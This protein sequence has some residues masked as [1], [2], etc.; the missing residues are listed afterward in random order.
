MDQKMTSNRQKAIDAYQQQMFFGQGLKLERRPIQF[1]GVLERYNGMKLNDEEY[2][3]CLAHMEG[4]ISV[5]QLDEI[6]SRRRPKSINDIRK[7]MGYGPMA[8]TR[9]NEPKEAPKASPELVEKTILETEIYREA[10][11]AIVQHPTFGSESTKVIMD[12]QRKQ[13]AYGLDKYPEPLN[14]NTWSIEETVQHILDES[15]DKLHYLVM[16][17]IK[18]RQYLAS[19][20]NNVV[21]FRNT[22]SRIDAISRMIDDT[23]GHM[24]YLIS[25]NNKRPNDHMDAIA[26]SMLMMSGADM[27]GDK[28]HTL[29]ADGIP[30][31]TY[32][33]SDQD[34]MNREVL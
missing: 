29:Y 2:N 21:D 28:T 4:H 7:E 10:R 32:T 17:R 24:D 16:L 8:D 30:Y 15:I 23:I 6:L 25:I 22:T 13:V 18:L 20:A 33:S 3:F 31:K 34:D 5:E 26:Y 1:S 27:D 12:A 14:P 19:V 11:L 9:Y